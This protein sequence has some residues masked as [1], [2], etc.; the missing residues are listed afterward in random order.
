MANKCICCGVDGNEIRLYDSIFNGRICK[1]CERCSIIENILLIKKPEASKLKESEKNF[2]VYDRLKQIKGIVKQKT[3]DSFFREDKLKKLDSNP[4]YELPEKE[5]LNLID[6]FH[7]EIMKNRRRKGLSQRQLAEL[8]GESEILI[9]MIEKENLPE[10]PEVLIRKLEQFF[11]IKLRKSNFVENYLKIK[12]QRPILLDE[13]GNRLEKIPEKHFED[14]SK[15]SSKDNPEDLFKENKDLE[16]FK[17]E[18]LNE[19]KKLGEDN[20]KEENKLEERKIKEMNPEDKFKEKGIDYEKGEFDIT[21]ADLGNINISDLKKLNKKRI[22]VTKQEKKEEQGRIEE[23]QRLIEARRE[24]LRLIKQ[25]KSKE[26]D[27]LLGGAELLKTDLKE[28]ELEE[29]TLEEA[30]LKKQDLEEEAII[31]EFDEKLI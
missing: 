15:D 18:E 7:W 22:E 3:P 10:N 8:I 31:E 9:Q 17:E 20:L 28:E 6:H 16:E 12:D 14:S 2:R 24:E 23:K 19:L 4:L 27:D 11:Q 26:I 1:V 25:K 13:R 5:K 29:E 21:K 30:E